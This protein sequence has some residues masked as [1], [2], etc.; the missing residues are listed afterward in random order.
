MRFSRQTKTS[1]LIA[2]SA[3]CTSVYAQNNPHTSTC[4][5]SWEMNASMLQGEWMASVEGRENAALLQLGPHPEWQGTVKGEITRNGERHAMVGDVNDG[6]VTL[7]ESANGIN[8]SATWLGDVTDGSCAREIR[9][10]YQTGD[11]DNTPT[12]SFV[13]RKRTP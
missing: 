7:E 5:E 10:Q 13:L 1:L 8:I 3:L 11:S 2:L 6:A 9:G 12:Q 4:P